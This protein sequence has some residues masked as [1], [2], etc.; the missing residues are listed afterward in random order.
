MH[1]VA[2]DGRSSGVTPVS[3]VYCGCRAFCWYFGSMESWGNSNGWIFYWPEHRN[4]RISIVGV[5]YVSN[6]SYQTFGAEAFCTWRRSQAKP[7]R[8]YQT[9]GHCGPWISTRMECLLHMSLTLCQVYICISHGQ[10]SFVSTIRMLTYHIAA[11]V[12]WFLFIYYIDRRRSRRI[13]L[14]LPP[15]PKPL[16]LIGNL[17]DMPSSFS[18][19]TYDRWFKELRRCSSILV[20]LYLKLLEESDII[21]VKSAGI[22]IIIL[23]TQEAAVELLERR[24]GLYSSRYVFFGKHSDFQRG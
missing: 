21:Y 18:W 16:P 13:N 24:S 11:G 2:S 8:S 10:S 14:P 9:H 4:W 12:V 3:P 22:D 19:E 7:E 17:L 23:K 6:V 1:D 15:G 20:A 5:G